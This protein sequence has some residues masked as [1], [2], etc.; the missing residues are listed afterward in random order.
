M[1]TIKNGQNTIILTLKA[2]DGVIE[3]KKGEDAIASGAVVIEA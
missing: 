2:A 3:L 1:L